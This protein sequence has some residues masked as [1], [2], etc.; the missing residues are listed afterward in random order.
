MYLSGNYNELSVGRVD[1][2]YLSGSYTDFNFGTVTRIL[3]MDGNYGDLEVDELRAGFQRVEVRASYTDVQIDV[4]DAAG[5]TLDLS[6]RYGDI[7]A[8][9]NN[10]SPRNIGSDSGTDYVRGAKAGTGNGSI[11]ITTNY[12]DI[13]LY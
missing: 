12:G 10:L 13:E 5:Y 6:S 4:D 3:E 2:A 9:T 11:K 7:D 8:P 1:E